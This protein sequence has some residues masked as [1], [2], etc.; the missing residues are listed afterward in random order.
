MYY[1]LAKE[2]ERKIN[3]SSLMCEISEKK[4]VAKI[5][6]HKEYDLVCD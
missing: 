1:V 4:I 2:H 5:E 6:S 3:I